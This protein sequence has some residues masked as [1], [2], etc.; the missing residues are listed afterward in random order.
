MGRSHWD[1]CKKEQVGGSAKW[2]LSNYP[3]M[4]IWGVLGRD[5]AEL[6]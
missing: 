4:K 3:Y 6:N 1:L 5:I 2:E